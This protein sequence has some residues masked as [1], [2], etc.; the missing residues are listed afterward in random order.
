MNTSNFTVIV[1]YTAAPI[2]IRE[3]DYEAHLDDDP[4]FGSGL[5][6]TPVEALRSLAD[7]LEARGVN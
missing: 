4:E 2:P 3:C 6:P 5:G 1:S 7:M